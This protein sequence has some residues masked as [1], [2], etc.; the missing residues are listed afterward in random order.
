MTLYHIVGGKTFYQKGCHHENQIVGVE[1]E[2]T[3]LKYRTADEIHRYNVRSLGNMEN[4]R[5]SC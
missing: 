5:A 4:P 1:K 2:K 3:R